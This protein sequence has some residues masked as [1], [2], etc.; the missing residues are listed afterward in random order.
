MDCVQLGSR[1]AGDALRRK[2]LEHMDS[3]RIGGI[4]VS[5]KFRSTGPMHMVQCC[6]RFSKRT[7][8]DSGAKG[9]GQPE[10]G[11]SRGARSD[12]DVLRR[13]L[14]QAA[15]SII[16]D[17]VEQAMIAEALR[18]RSPGMPAGERAEVSAR[19]RRMLAESP[20][21]PECSDLASRIAEY[22][23]ESD[24]LLL[25]GYMQFRMRSYM[26]SIGMCVCD[27]LLAHLADREHREFVRLL[28]MFVDTQEEREGTV[29][30]RR[31][32]DG[33]F[34]LLTEEGGSIQSQ[35]VDAI[36]ADLV[37]EG[38]DATD[39]LVSALIS[40]APSRIVLHFISDQDT[41]DTVETVFEG[42]VERCP[43]V[44]CTVV[45]CERAL[46]PKTVQVPNQDPAGHSPTGRL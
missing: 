27:A 46:V 28:K 33:A 13:C 37:N 18:S 40:V 26:I 43:G 45:G 41:L 4:N 35:L 22:L 8:A 32:L 24:T 7:S 29:H 14:S 10:P 5:M 30:V 1:V 21:R 12:G 9:D 36:V 17:E 19:A 44:N 2:V 16:L 11:S 34:E 3:L 31:G 38:V 15:A 25:E 23:I 6:A 20:Q 42:R 39:L